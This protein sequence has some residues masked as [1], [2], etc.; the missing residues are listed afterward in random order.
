MSDQGQHLV[1]AAKGALLKTRTRGKEL[2]KLRMKYPFASALLT[3]RQ[4]FDLCQSFKICSPLYEL[5]CT[6]R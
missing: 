5:G 6:I 1:W 4:P 3:L 2:I